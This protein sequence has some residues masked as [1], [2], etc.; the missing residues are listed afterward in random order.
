VVHCYPTSGEPVL[1]PSRLQSREK[2]G[3][4]HWLQAAVPTE[5]A[6]VNVVFGV[7]AAPPRSLRLRLSPLALEVR[8]KECCLLGVGLRCARWSSCGGLLALL[9]RSAFR[10]GAAITCWYFSLP[11]C[12]WAGR[13]RLH[14]GEFARHHGDSRFG[15]CRGW[16]RRGIVC[17]GVSAVAAN[18]SSKQK[19]SVR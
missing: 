14:R 5:V 19:C 15:S 18:W 6:T 2:G 13:G 16:R 7:M 12:C 11:I 17:G 4:L 1:S 3:G 10:C 8:G 9:L